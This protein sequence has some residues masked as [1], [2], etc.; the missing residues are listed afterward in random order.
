ML[1][2]MA[3]SIWIIAEASVPAETR[4]PCQPARKSFPDLH[5]ILCVNTDQEGQVVQWTLT[6]R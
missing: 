1:W 5:A 3:T 2:Q 6:W 4:R